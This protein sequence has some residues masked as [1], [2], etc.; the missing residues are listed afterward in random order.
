MS[1]AIR[2]G[3]GGWT[4]E[5]WRDGVFFPKGLSHAKELEYAARQ[6]SSIEINGTYYRTQT[7]ATF[8]KWAGQTP[9]RFVFSVKALR[10]TTNRKVL[11]E[12]GES[13]GKFLGSGLVEL[14]DKL[15][16]ILWQFAPTKRFEPQ[17][18]GG[19][20]ALLPQSQDGVRLRHA[21][22][23][24]HDSFRDPAFVELARRYG[25]AIVFAHSDKYP[26][27][28]DL[29]ADFVY[30]RLE[31]TREAVETG[32]TAEELDRWAQVARGWSR[33]EAPDGLDYAAGSKGDGHARDAFVYMIS[34]AKVRAPAAAMALIARLET[35]HD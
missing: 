19:F 12:A 21:L 18:F 29:T 10:Y 34:G 16:P 23:V 25:A 32:Y 2:I 24:R 35:P 17:D 7:P 27:I 22:E 31:S 20:L 3:V 15:G 13:V 33:G 11:S 6:L 4:Y 8:A 28:A 30:A 26:A 1:G 5:P 14:G 9:D